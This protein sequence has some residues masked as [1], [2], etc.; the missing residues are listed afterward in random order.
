MHCDV[1]LRYAATDFLPHWRFRVV[2]YGCYLVF[3]FFKQKTAYEI[4]T[5]DWSSDVCSSDLAL[6]QQEMVSI[7]GGGA[8][9]ARNDQYK[10]QGRCRNKNGRSEE[11]RVGK[12]CRSRWS[13]YH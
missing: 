9:A 3:F 2:M 8:A 4:G 11:R 12:E 6:P 5:G 1:G 10:K 13:P 7:N